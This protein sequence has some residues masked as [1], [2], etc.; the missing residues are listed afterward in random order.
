MITDHI[1]PMLHRTRHSQG[2][3]PLSTCL[4]S[5]GGVDQSNDLLKDSTI[6]QQPSLP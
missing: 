6:Q 4:R 5:V 2:S 3:R 1:P